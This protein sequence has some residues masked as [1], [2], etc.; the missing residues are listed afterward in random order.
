MAVIVTLSG[1]SFN[2][3]EAIFGKEYSTKI[4]HK[5]AGRF[6]TQ[7]RIAWYAIEHCTCR[8]HTK[9][10]R[11]I[12]QFL[13]AGEIWKHHSHIEKEGATKMGTSY[14]GREKGI[15]CEVSIE[16]SYQFS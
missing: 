16:L 7:N 13:F 2:L 15:R 4:L 11:Q 1:S 10:Y 6:A 9:E 8:C 3:R 12:S 5:I 14:R